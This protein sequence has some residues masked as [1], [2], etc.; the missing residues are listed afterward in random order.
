MIDHFRTDE[1]RPT[2]R[3]FGSRIA[4]YLLD[5]QADQ[6][7]KSVIYQR[8]RERESTWILKPF[9]ISSTRSSMW[10][11]AS[12]TPISFTP[13]FSHPP[14]RTRNPFHPR[15]W[16]GQSAESAHVPRVHVPHAQ[17]E[18]ARASARARSCPVRL[19]CAYN[20]TRL[21]QRTGKKR[22]FGGVVPGGSVWIGI[23]GRSMECMV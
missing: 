13:S 14:P 18:D 3:P 21:G 16:D 10:V 15:G 17:P 7:R 1:E 11:G 22:P 12:P 23:Y 20:A 8:E 2:S 9:G 5:S 19:P 6:Q 4:G